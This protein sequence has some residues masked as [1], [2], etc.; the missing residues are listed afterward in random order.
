MWVRYT[1]TYPDNALGK[2]FNIDTG[3]EMWIVHYQDVY[4]IKMRHISG[5]DQIYLTNENGFTTLDD[6]QAALKNITHAQYIAD[7]VS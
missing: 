4:Q 6:A 2:V 3:M 5:E 1:E 7:I